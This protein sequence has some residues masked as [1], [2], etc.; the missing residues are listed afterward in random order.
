[1]PSAITPK[2]ERWDSGTI[3]KLMVLS[4]QIEARKTQLSLAESLEEPSRYPSKVHL[5]PN[6][7]TSQ[8]MKHR[9]KAFDYWRTI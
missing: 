4:M 9:L 3:V 2:N 5:V 6:A 8:S 7:L 1:M